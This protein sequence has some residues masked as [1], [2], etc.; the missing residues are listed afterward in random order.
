MYLQDE[1]EADEKYRVH[2][3]YEE[4]WLV[5]KMLMNIKC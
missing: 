1:M 2:E 5:K 4:K 3:S